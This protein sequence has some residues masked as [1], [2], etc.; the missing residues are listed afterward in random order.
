MPWPSLASSCSGGSL[1]FF[2]QESSNA[3]GLQA[4]IL[5]HILLSVLHLQVSFGPISWLMVGEVFPLAVRG[6]AAALATLTNF[7]SN[8]LVSTV[9]TGFN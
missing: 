9:M 7:G 4:Y 6:P 2:L 8:F 1:L 3:S 5:K